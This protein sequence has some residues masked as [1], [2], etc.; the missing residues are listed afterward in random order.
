M[1]RYIFSFIFRC[2]NELGLENA[3]AVFLTQE[4]FL[5][6]KFGFGCGAARRRRGGQ[7]YGTTPDG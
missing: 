5:S 1:S 7:G 4:L 6:E 3:L 2:V